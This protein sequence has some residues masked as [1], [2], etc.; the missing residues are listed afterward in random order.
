[1]AWTTLPAL[2]PSERLVNGRPERGGRERK[3]ACLSPYS[4]NIV[5]GVFCEVELLLY[6]VLGSSAPH[7]SRRARTA[8]G[9]E[10]SRAAVPWRGKGAPSL[11]LR[12]LYYRG[13]PERVPQGVLVH[14]AIETR[15]S[16]IMPG[17]GS[18]AVSGGGG[19]RPRFAPT[20]NPRGPGPP[21]RGRPYRRVLCAHCKSGRARA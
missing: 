6:G 12:R 5:E 16:A 21:A 14:N 2:F 13:R 4:P 19:G 15:I 1:L 17:F 8:G 7:R 9:Q 20:G 18:A 11:T 10:K 3:R